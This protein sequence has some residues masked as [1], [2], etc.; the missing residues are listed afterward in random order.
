M[1]TG[2]GIDD[3]RESGEARHELVPQA[4]IER[5]LRTNRPEGEHA[6]DGAVSHHKPRSATT[7]A[8]TN[9]M[10]DAVIVRDA[11]ENG[12]CQPR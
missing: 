7:L 4:R 5:R 2:Q 3:A 12:Q 8:T 9:A 11:P 10:I 6:Q 1:A